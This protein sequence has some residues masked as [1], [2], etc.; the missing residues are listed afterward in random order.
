MLNAK[1]L[2]P[3]R[4]SRLQFQQLCNAFIGKRLVADL[5]AGFYTF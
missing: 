4:R 3:Y 1:R 2:R 5:C